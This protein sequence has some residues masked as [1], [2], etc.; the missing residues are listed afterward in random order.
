M[1]WERRGWLESSWGCHPNILRWFTAWVLVPM[2]P[3]SVRAAFK[4]CEVLVIHCVEKW[5]DHI[6]L[7]VVD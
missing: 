3:N 6:E 2:S 1:V 7:C 4:S 5:K